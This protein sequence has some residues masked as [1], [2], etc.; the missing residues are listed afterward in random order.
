ME[1]ELS[2]SLEHYKETIAL[3]LTAKQLLFSV[4]SVGAGALIILI[5]YKKV[6]LT[7]S[8]Y[9]ATPAVVPLAMGGFYNYHGLTFRQFLH[10]MIHFTFFNR[11]L[12]Y[13][14]TE[15][16]VELMEAFMAGEKEKAEEEQSGKEGKTNMR[17]V[18]RKA[19]LLIAGVLVALA[20]ITAAA[21]WWKA[22]R[23]SVME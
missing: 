2:E 22:K 16:V 1:I 20:V 13:A 12:I 7:A 10:K 15:N 6:G 11:P 9:I 21:V 3:G 17:D 14:S 4:L 18:K 5:L 8:C 19:V 23:L